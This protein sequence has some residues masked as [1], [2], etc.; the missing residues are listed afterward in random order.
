MRLLVI[1]DSY[2]MPDRASGDLRFWRLLKVIAKTNDVTFCITGDLTWQR[3]I[4]GYEDTGNYRRRLEDLGISILDSR[5]REAVMSMVFDVVLFEFFY[6]A[7]PLIDDIKLCLP[8]SRIIVD[9]VDVAYQ[10]LL[11]K[12]SVTGEAE[13]AKAA[14]LVKKRE[15][16]VYKKADLVI[17]V[18]EADARLLGEESMMI[19][20]KVIPNIHEVPPMD[21]ATSRRSDVLIFVGSFLHEPNVDAMEYFC[22]DVLP[23]V[24]KDFPSVKLLIVGTSPPTSI[25]R[26]ACDKVSVLGHVPDLSPYLY[27]SYISIA[28]L[29]YGS[30]MKGKV[31][32]AMAHGLPVVTTTIGMEGIGLTPMKDV[33]I[34]DTPVDFAKAI[35]HL[36]GDRQLYDRIRGNAWSFVRANYSEE[37]VAE[38]VNVFL[39]RLA[40]VA[41]KRL[42]V[43]TF[44]R[45]AIRYHLNR[46]LLWRFRRTSSKII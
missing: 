7:E 39:S 21:H 46:H 17:T 12:A 45:R 33:L 4:V 6:C 10:R 15:L 28:P 42:P 22:R 26:L 20:T 31:C 27:S 11:R 3:S 37:A 9:S 38:R 29:R 32:E 44:L 16:A 23:L 30:G 2:P 36:L 1:A 43:A 18:T 41:V 19:R 8:R 34:A 5:P 40:D 13:H 25:Q 24:H 14:R 35:G